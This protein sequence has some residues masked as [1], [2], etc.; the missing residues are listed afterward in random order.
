MIGVRTRRGG[1]GRGEPDKPSRGRRAGEAGGAASSR[2]TR[3]VAGAKCEPLKRPDSARVVH[4]D[5]DACKEEGSDH[6]FSTN[7]S[8][9]NRATERSIDP[10]PV[11]WTVRTRAVHY[12]HG[13]SVEEG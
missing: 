4:F 7:L 8:L 9:A 13:R 12:G 10:L 2:G 6:S 3:T 5:V 1:G 11:V